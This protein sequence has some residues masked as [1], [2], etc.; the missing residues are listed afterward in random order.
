MEAMLDT[1]YQRRRTL[2]HID[3]DNFDVLVWLIQ[4]VRLHVFYRVDHLESR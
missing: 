1:K 3:V 2:F 4:L